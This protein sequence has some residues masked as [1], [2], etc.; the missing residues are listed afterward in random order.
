MMWYTLARLIPYKLRYYVVIN[1]AADAT[2]GEWSH[3][4]STA[5]NIADI[6]KRMK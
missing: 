6:L 1:A 5:V 2:T 3:V 4:E